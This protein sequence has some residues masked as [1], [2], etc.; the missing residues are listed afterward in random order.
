[1]TTEARLVA[2]ASPRL[3]VLQSA[4]FS[5]RSRFVRFAPIP[6]RLIVGLGFIDHGYLK[7]SRGPEVF[8]AVLQALGVPFP[9][10]AAWLTIGT[11]LIGGLA[12]L[13]GALVTLVSIPLAVLLLVSIVTVHLPFGFSSIKLLAVTSA[14]PQFGKPGYELSLI[15]LACLATLVLGGAGP[16]AIDNLF[17]RW[18]GTTTA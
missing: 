13:T 1:M 12:I 2:P 9:H 5:N 4:P 14:G 11:E 15:Y 6:L 3:E 8:A 16:L 7:L 17:Q 18:K 10:F